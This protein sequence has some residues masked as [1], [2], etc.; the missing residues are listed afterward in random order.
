M[1]HKGDTLGLSWKQVQQ[2]FGGFGKGIFSQQRDYSIEEVEGQK[3]SGTCYWVHGFRNVVKRRGR[4]KSNSLDIRNIWS[5]RNFK[6][7]G[8]IW[9]LPIYSN[10]CLLFIKRINAYEK[11]CQCHLRVVSNDRAWH[12]SVGDIQSEKWTAWWKKK[13]SWH[14]SQERS[15][16]VWNKSSLLL[17]MSVLFQLPCN[18]KI[19]TESSAS[20]CSSSDPLSPFILLVRSHQ[21]YCNCQFKIG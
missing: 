4:E 9:L 8:K 16:R 2:T 18:T 1:S 19:Q 11:F 17:C 20:W 14:A 10:E 6:L 13:F 15:A 5:K 12:V 21:N 7:W 3:M